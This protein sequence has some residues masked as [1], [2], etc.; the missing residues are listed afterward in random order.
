[1]ITKSSKQGHEGEYD[2]EAWAKEIAT[3]EY[4]HRGQTPCRICSTVT[5]FVYTGL[6]KDR[7]KLPIIC[8]TCKQTIASWGNI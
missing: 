3:T 2:D 4:T 7:R 8:D 5:Q 1:M 6:V